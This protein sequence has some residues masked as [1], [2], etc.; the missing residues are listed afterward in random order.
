[1]SDFDSP[2]GSDAT[3]DDIAAQAAA[4]AAA[5]WLPPGPR[6]TPKKHYITA[7]A[8]VTVSPLT[9]DEG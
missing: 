3:N 4:D 7:A 9:S 5:F 8:A 2:M 6:A 1:M